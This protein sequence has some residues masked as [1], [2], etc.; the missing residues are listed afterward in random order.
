MTTPENGA[1]HYTITPIN[2]AAHLFRVTCCVYT[3]D[4][5]GQVFRLPAWIPGSYMIREFARNIV[6]L[7]A[8]CDGTIIACEKIDKASWRCEPVDGVLSVTCD[9]YA[10]DLSVRAAHLDDTHGYFNGTSVFLAVA[11]KE[12][13]PCRVTINPPEGDAFLRWQVATSLP[14]AANTARWSFGDYRAENYDELID[15]PVEMGVF[16]QASFDA[17]GVPHDVVV[18]GVHRAD[19]NRL[20]RDLQKI[21]ETQIRFFGEPAPMN[22]YLFLVMVVGEGYGGLEHRASTSLLVSRDDLPLLVDDPH[23]IKESYRGFLGLCSH[24]YFHT[25]NVKRIKPAAFVPYDLSRENHTRQLWVFEGFTSYYDDLLL[26]RSGLITAES[27]LEL[28][29]QNITRVLRGAGRYKQ[30]VA[31]SS[32]DAWI[33][34]YRQDENSPNA[35]VSYYAKGAMV[36][37]ALDLEMRRRTDGA[38]SLDDVMRTLWL[39]HGLTGV[40]VGEDGV[41]A[42]AEEI[43]GA[44][45]E[46]FFAQAVYGTEDLPLAGLFDSFGIDLRLRA[47]SNQADIGGKP[48]TGDRE[49][50]SLG[51]RTQSD[52]L[53]ARIQHCLDGGAAMRAGLSAGDVIVAIDALRVTQASI[54]KILQGYRPGESL[55]LHAFRRDEL[56]EFHVTA[57]TV[58]E[59]TCFLVLRPGERPANTTQWLGGVTENA[60]G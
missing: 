54:E 52:T 28:L 39:R 43:I 47:A 8:E 35:V 16:A 34:Y 56:R 30:S 40:G 31:E 55:R 36:A 51:I 17:C 20:C 22:R 24:E 18:T 10:W 33:K 50:A 7:W 26:V 9:I 29:G 60:H 41:Q 3:P 15:H 45:L 53:G 44:S 59:D 25:W 5:A 12:N 27:Y 37:L 49:R 19:M 48:A 58:P 57:A 13:L 21:C 2:P 4:P 11:G 42:I 32:F 46:D 38:R 6:E 23:A 14:P 1:I